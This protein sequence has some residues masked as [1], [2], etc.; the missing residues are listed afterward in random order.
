MNVLN[1]LKKQLIVSC[2]ALEDEPLHSPAIMGKMA[3]AALEGGAKGIRANSVAD[4]KEIKQQV[5]L[6][7]IG[8][9]KQDYEDSDVYITPTIKEVKSLLTVKADIIAID[10]TNRKRP[11]NEDLADIVQYVKSQKN[12]VVLMADVSSVGDAIRAEKI[13][14]DC[15]STTLVGYT[16][17]TKGANIADNDFAL[18]KEIIAAVSIPVIAEGKIDTPLK[19]VKALENGAY[20]V[21]V[22]SAITR[23]Q[24]ITKT[25]SDSIKKHL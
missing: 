5:N 15:I 22:G 3:V 4:I 25:F 1:Q 12:N 21:V 6:P 16:E 8:I 2:Q 14:F 18:L 23:P 24:L 17:E 20:F 11:N 10:A 19:A 7:I 13:G 9:I